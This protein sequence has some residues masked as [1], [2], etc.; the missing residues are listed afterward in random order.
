MKIKGIIDEDFVNYKK[1]S[2]FIAFPNCTFKCEKEAGCEI[3]QNSKLALSPDLNIEES[4][5]IKRYLSNP[6]TKAIVFGGLEPFDSL[7]DIQAF[8]NC[9]RRQFNC[10]DTV[11]IYTGYTE[12]EIKEGKIYEAIK[13]NP[14]YIEHILNNILKEKNL[15]IKYGRFIP[16]QEKHFDPILGINLASPN[17][18]AKEYNCK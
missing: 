6:I 18:Y 2:M 16:N 17:Q 14:S 8:L 4:T 12:K 1:P 13:N 10:I 5:L 11:I 9:L 7:F 15:I 3:C